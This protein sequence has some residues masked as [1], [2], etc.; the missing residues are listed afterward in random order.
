MR[1]NAEAM[2]Q[3]EHENQIETTEKHLVNLY[4]AGKF[5]SDFFIKR[6]QLSVMPDFNEIIDPRF[7][8]ELLGE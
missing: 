8:N 7:V 1:E 6:G 4:G 3:H 5:I 2:T